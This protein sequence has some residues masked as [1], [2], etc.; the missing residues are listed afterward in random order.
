M[1]GSGKLL[2]GMVARL[3][4]KLAEPLLVAALAAIIG[5][6][7]ADLGWYHPLSAAAA[8]VLG[9]AFYAQGRQRSFLLLAVAGVFAFAHGQRLQRIGA[10]PFAE[11]IRAGH[12]L[13]VEIEGTIDSVPKPAARP[14]R[15]SFFVSL[16]Q[17]R[18][19]GGT[20]EP[21]TQRLFV[22]A[23]ADPLPEYGDH[24]RL[25]GSLR[26]PAGSRNP[27]EFD[28]GQFLERKGVIAQLSARARPGI[29]LVDS[30]RG[31]LIIAAA[32]RAR[33]WVAGTI[34]ADL[35]HRDPEIASVLTAM[36]LGSRDDARDEVIDSFRTSGTLHIFAV[37]GLHVGLI[38]VILWLLLTPLPLS[39]RVRALVIILILC[40][41]AF[42]TGLRPSAVRATIMASLVLAGPL[43]DREP[44]VINSL[45]AAG[46]A[47]LA[48][49]S[50]QLFLPGFQ[51]SFSVLL[52]LTLLHGP[53]L[54]LLL[55]LVSHDP[56]LPASLL[57]ERQRLFYRAARAIAETFAVSLAAW[58]G[59]LPLMLYH[60]NLVT[61]IAPI[62][63]LLLIPIAFCV[64]GTAILSTLSGVG[65]LATLCAILNNANFVWASLLTAT[66]MFFANLPPPVSHFYA[67][68]RTFFRPPCELTVL[69]LPRGGASTLI[70]TRA[71]QDWL[72]DTGHARDFRPTIASV[73]HQHAGITRLDAI[74]LTHTDAAHIGGT[75][76]VMDHFDPDT[77]YTPPPNR[78]SSSYRG[79]VENLVASRIEH[80]SPERGEM[81]PIDA[82]TSIEILYAPR[83]GEPQGISDDTCLVFILHSHGWKILFTGDSG[84]RTEQ[85]LVETVRDRLQAD[86]VIRGFHHTDHSMTPAFLDAVAPEAIIAGK[87]DF[88]NSAPDDG[89]WRTVASGRGI[90]LFDQSE[91]GAVSVRIHEGRLRIDSHIGDQS[92][93]LKRDR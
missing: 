16:T 87:R 36:T 24:I 90:E 23:F 75:G 88:E 44:R 33:R 92:L 21:A 13:L 5:I 4:Q 82:R 61:P 38:G 9:L 12:E 55:P 91:T 85:W 10:L 39:R 84:F 22:S 53:I 15:C 40:G 69:D 47:I 60:F 46:L 8:V 43:L 65:R 31:N 28:F 71:R 6:L 29:E 11:E 57:T 76:E 86:L 1:E 3:R 78:S 72:I 20:A 68:K 30:D 56:F 77:I 41:Y 62:A 80:R 52:A 26:R 35:S 19:I 79:L 73:L 66:A 14:G 45:G 49:D 64:L 70:A 81:I 17:I 83:P 63:N 89:Q 67:T 37:S 59:S 34:T 51:L 2:T 42:V 58:L 48:Y 25:G 32:N 54:S 27:G 7:L 50:Q 74:L 93:T 18:Q